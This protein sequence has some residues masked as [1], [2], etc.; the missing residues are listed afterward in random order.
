LVKQLI[1]EQEMNDL[2]EQMKGNLL[3]S[4]ENSSTHMWR[5]IQQEMYLQHHPLLPSTLRAIERLTR[6][7]IRSVAREVFAARPL[8]ITAVGPISAQ[9][10]PNVK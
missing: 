9:Q 7:D 3:L 6:E 8:T 5:M 1:T 4:L 10:V 2:R